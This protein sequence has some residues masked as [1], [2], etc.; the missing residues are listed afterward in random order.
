MMKSATAD[1]RLDVKRYKLVGQEL[2]E[3]L[4]NELKEDLPRIGM[5]FMMM[6]LELL[7][8]VCKVLMFKLLVHL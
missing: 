3:A 2:K 1:G 6:V 8:P 7:R 4:E 5:W